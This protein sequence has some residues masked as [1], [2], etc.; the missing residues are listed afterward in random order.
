MRSK[1]HFV[2]AFLAAGVS[3]TLALLG[4]FFVES[5]S[6]TAQQKAQ[7]AQEYVRD[8]RQIVNQDK[9]ADVLQEIDQNAKARAEAK[10]DPKEFLQKR[11]LRLPPDAEVR[12][13][14]GSF[15]LE[16]CWRGWCL[17]LTKQGKQEA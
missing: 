6:V 12:V 13:I 15:S 2:I 9:L 14:E 16:F 5:R 1:R 8:V 11:G 7:S 10:R 17:K 3:L 4:A